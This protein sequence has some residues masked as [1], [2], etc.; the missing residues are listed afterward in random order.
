MDW[1]KIAFSGGTVAAILLFLLPMIWN[2]WKANQKQV[3][4][5]ISINMDTATKS[6]N[7]KVLDVKEDLKHLRDMH[8]DHYEFQRMQIQKTT[9]IEVNLNN[10]IKSFDKLQNEH[11]R[12]HSNNGKTYGQ[13]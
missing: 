12:N 7:E 9:E 13:S 2:L 10:V 6:F 3:I 4:K 5:T 11:T 8:E 1:S